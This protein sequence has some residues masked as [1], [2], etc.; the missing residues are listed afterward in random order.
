MKDARGANGGLEPQ[1]QG[2]NALI[3]IDALARPVRD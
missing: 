3:R 2:W 1:L